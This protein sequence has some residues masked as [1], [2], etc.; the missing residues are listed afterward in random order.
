MLGCETVWCE[1]HRVGQRVVNGRWDCP[2]GCAHRDLDRERRMG[3]DRVCLRCLCH[4][5]DRNWTYPD[6]R[7]IALQEAARERAKAAQL[8]LAV[9][10]F[11]KREQARAGKK[12]R[13]SVARSA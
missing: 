3:F 9:R 7:L 13:P 4:S 12:Q 2:N 5:R 6:S 1:A 10:M 11:G 8:T